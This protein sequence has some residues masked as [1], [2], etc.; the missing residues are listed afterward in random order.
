LFGGHEGARPIGVNP[1]PGWGDEGG[2]E[3]G[4]ESSDVRQRLI[5]EVLAGGSGGSDTGWG[6]TSG[7]ERPG[8]AVF[9][10]I[11]DAPLIAATDDW[12]DLNNPRAL[13]GVVANV[14]GER[15]AVAARAAGG[16][17]ARA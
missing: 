16:R 17:A 7:N 15:A 8:R 11:V 9:D 6:D 12:G 10:Q 5:G 2:D 3:G 4:S 14:A 1:E 13:V